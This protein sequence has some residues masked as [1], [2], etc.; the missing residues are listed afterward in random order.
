[1]RLAEMIDFL[2]EYPVHEPLPTHSELG[3]PTDLSR[4]DIGTHDDDDY[5]RL[6]DLYEDPEAVLRAAERRAARRRRRRSR[7]FRDVKPPARAKRLPLSTS[8]SIAFRHSHE[9]A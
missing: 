6:R 7:P 2:D 8:T 4:F 5:L 9:A 3:L 1:M